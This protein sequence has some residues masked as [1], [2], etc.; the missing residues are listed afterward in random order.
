[1]SD[2]ALIMFFIVAAF[3]L[4]IITGTSINV[5]IK[6]QIGDSHD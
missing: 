1:M 6:R 2:V 5:S 4:G 3:A